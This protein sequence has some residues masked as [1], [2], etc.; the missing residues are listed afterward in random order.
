M[1]EQ[2]GIESMPPNFTDGFSRG[3]A[4]NNDKTDQPGAANVAPMPGQHFPCGPFR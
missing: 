1:R 4:L 2:A 3:F